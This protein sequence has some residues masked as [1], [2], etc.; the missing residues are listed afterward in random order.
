MESKNKMNIKTFKPIIFA[1]TS[2]FYCPSLYSDIFRVTD[3]LTCVV[4]IK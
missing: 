1:S 4:T 3:E 2:D